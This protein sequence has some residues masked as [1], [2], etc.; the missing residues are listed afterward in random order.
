MEETPEY[1]LGLAL[2]PVES[3]KT[4]LKDWIDPDDLDGKLK[5]VKGSL[6]LRNQNGGILLVG[7]RDDCTRNTT[8]PFPD[9]G[10]TFDQEKIQG[11]VANY[12]STPFELKV[13]LI[14]LDGIHY[15]AIEVLGGF[16]FPIACK[17][18]LYDANGT[19]KLL[20]E[21]A[22]YVRTLTTNNFVS[23]ASLKHTDI[24]DL[25]ERCFANREADI[26]RLLRR[27]LTDKNVEVIREAF[28]TE[29]F[30]RVQQESNVLISERLHEWA[31]RYAYLENDRDD[32]PDHGSFE[33][34]VIVTDVG[35]DY[36]PTQSF[37]R[38][39]LSRNPSLTGWPIWLDSRNFTDNASHPTIH[40]DGWE[41]F[42]ASVSGHRSD[43]HLDYWYISG[44]G[45][46]Y[47][48]RAFQDDIG[49]SDR[50][51]QAGAALDIGLVILRT[52][53]AILVALEYSSVF[54]PNQDS[55]LIFGFRWSGL[56]G[57]QLSTW[58]DQNRF[59]G[60]YGASTADQAE[61]TIV[62]DQEAA[63]DS[64]AE[65]VKLAIAPLFSKFN[66]WECPDNW[67]EDL[68]NRLADRR[69]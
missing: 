18:D 44:K 62:I 39:I 16:R 52:A 49:G 30:A 19:R 6:A 59:G 32:I 60:N 37:L 9:V 36:L 48:R 38:N 10:Q 26:G 58:A 23:T 66:G 33:V 24:Q 11:M 14:P 28:S 61:S 15:V 40:E 13:W 8:C 43:Q 67:V 21:H 4:E 22:I 64:I 12:S 55:N 47:L 5:I 50:A 29:T 53:E 63:R 68:V 65:Y 56:H 41:A 57:R 7:V 34:G 27:H 42:I 2:N 35:K 51:P 54:E 25:F 31:E 3:L 20:S 1:V 46:L 69:L 45:E 17:R